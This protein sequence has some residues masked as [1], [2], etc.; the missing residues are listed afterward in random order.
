[1]THDNIIKLEPGQK[2]IWEEHGIAIFLHVEQ[3]GEMHIVW[4]A[5]EGQVYST[6]PDQINHISNLIS[7]S[8][9]YIAK[10]TVCVVTFVLTWICLTITWNMFAHWGGY[11][12]ITPGQGFGFLAFLLLTIFCITANIKAIVH[13]KDKI[14]I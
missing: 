1:M 11:A 14:N 10:A 12:K 5:Y 2:I 8:Q 13:T 4:L 7:N 9:Y 6:K 3:H